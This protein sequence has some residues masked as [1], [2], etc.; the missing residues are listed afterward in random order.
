MH[1]SVYAFLNNKV[2]YIY[3]ARYQTPK[4]RSPEMWCQNATRI[5]KGELYFRTMRVDGHKLRTI[6][7]R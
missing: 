1:F 5:Q 4:M 7:K 2:V 3:F 6:Q